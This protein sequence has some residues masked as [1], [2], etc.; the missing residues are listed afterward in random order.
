MLF[1]SIRNSLPEYTILLVHEAR[2]N[3]LQRIVQTVVDHDRIK[4]EIN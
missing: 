2:L 1:R 4:L 3:K